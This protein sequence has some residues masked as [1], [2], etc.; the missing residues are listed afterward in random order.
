MNY[1][2]EPIIYLIHI[3]QHYLQYSYAAVLHITDNNNNNKTLR[4]SR[5]EWLAHR[6]GIYIYIYVIVG[7]AVYNILTYLHNIIIMYT[8]RAPL[9]SRRRRLRRVRRRRHAFIANPSRDGF[10]YRF[11]LSFSSLS[12]FPSVASCI[13]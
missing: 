1:I 4:V 8:P 13:G 11:S 6:V 5:V 3:L 7:L 2:T 10:S 9:S 12:V